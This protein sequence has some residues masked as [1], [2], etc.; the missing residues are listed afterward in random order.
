MSYPADMKLCINSEPHQYDNYLVCVKCHKTV[1]EIWE[2]AV[3]VK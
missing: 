3:P 1:D 2:V